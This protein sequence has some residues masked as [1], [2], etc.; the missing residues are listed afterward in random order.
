MHREPADVVK[1]FLY[2]FFD[3]R[4]G[5][6]TVSLFAFPFSYK[7]VFSQFSRFFPAFLPY[8]YIL[9]DKTFLLHPKEELRNL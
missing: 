6:K 7:I 8:G 4:E 2:K 3:Y 9:P 1:A 5:G